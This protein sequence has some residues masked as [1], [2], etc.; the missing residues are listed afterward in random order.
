M[1][2]GFVHEILERHDYP[3]GINGKLFFVVEDEDIEAFECFRL[4]D[5][6]GVDERFDEILII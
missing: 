1:Y 4:G 3:F 2:F 6:V 5:V